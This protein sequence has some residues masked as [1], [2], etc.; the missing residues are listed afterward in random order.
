MTFGAFQASKSYRQLWRRSATRTP[1]LGRGAASLILGSDARDETAELQIGDRIEVGTTGLVNDAKRVETRGTVRL[2]AAPP[3]GYAWRVS[4]TVGTFTQDIDFPASVYGA[5]NFPVEFSLD[6]FALNVAGLAGVVS[7]T[8]A[9]EFTS[10]PL[11]P[12][13]AGVPV[14]VVLPSVYFDQLLAPE[15][16]TS[17]LYVADRVP[18]P[19]QRSVPNALTPI[20][21]RLADTN[22]AGVDLAN[23]TILV[24]GIAVYNAGAF[25]T[26]WSGSVV[27]GTGPTG[28]DVTVFLTP[29]AGFFPLGSEQEVTLRVVS[30]LNGALSP[31]DTSWGFIAADTIAPAVQSAVMID[32]RT[33]RVRFTDDVLL[34]TST[35]GALN[36]ANY[37]ITRVSV[38][39]VRLAVVNVLPV[40]ASTRAVDVVLDIEASQGAQYTLLAKDVVDDGGNALEAIG[41]EAQ[42][43]GFVPAKPLGRRFELLDF[44]PQF[45]IAEDRTAD[46]GGCETAPGSGDLRRLLS[47]LQDLVDLLLCSVDEWTNIIDIDLAPEAFVDAIL[48]DL[49]NPFADCIADLSLIDKRRLANILISIYKQ[50][51]TANGIINAVRFFTGVEVTLDVIN[52]RQFW[53]LDVS[54]LGIDT[55]LA[56]PVG[57]PLWYSFWIVSPIVLTEEQRSR[58][59]C[60]ATYM[61]AAHEHV[62]G[63]IEPGSPPEPRQYWILNVSL[64]GAASPPTTLL[65]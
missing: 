9:L 41:R 15:T 18:A 36:P 50:K 27:T 6:D 8:F 19:G 52:F 37:A 64:L 65:S 61:K 25:I 55:I 59:L 23:T 24:D 1:P 31:I 20:T 60:I 58:I 54:L 10:D 49:G 57:S 40:F 38:P 5:L 33:V 51:G 17:E 42:F 12:G 2:N 44:V 29:P 7:L 30:Q 53:E 32:K 13:A 47:V 26:P 62:L 46:E 56:P 28:S 34:D 16:L 35:S 48:Q 14:S 39:A 21:F 3:E 11:N 4:I 43:L 63:I 45:N 22:G